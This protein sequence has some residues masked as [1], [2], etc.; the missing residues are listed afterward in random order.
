MMNLLS[1]TLLCITNV[2]AQT[3]FFIATDGS[4]ANG[5]TQEKP[6][7][8][9]K[10]AQQ[11]IQDLKE[12]GKYPD[13]G[14]TVLLRGGHYFVQE[15][16]NLKQADS[17]TERGGVLY[18]SYPGETVRLSGAQL[19]KGW[20]SVAGDIVKRLG[21][22]ARK[23][24]L[25]VNLKELGIQNFGELKP[26][27]MGRPGYS[28]A[29]ELLFDDRPMTLARYPNKGW[30]KIAS[31]P[32]GKDGGKFGYSG[33][34]PARW[35]EQDVWVHG[36]WTYDWADSYERAKRVDSANRLIETHPPHGKY[37]YRKGKRF[38][39][40]NV[41]E[42]LDS[43]GEW[44]L[45]RSSGMLYFWPP[46]LAK[47]E[48]HAQQSPIEIGQA[49]VSVT[50]MLLQLESVSN[51]E[52]RGLSFEGCR[53]TAVVIRGGENNRVSKCVFRNIGNKAVSIA[54][55][56]N[57]GVVGCDISE[58]GDGGISLSGGDRKTLTPAGH[59][60]ENNHIHHYSR[61][62]RTYR[63]GVMVSGVGNRVSHN[64][65]HH[66]PHNGIQL[67]GNDHQIEFNELHNLCE[68]TGDVG[69]FYMGRDWTARGTVIR[70]NFFHHIYGP[71]THGAM[72]VYLDDTASGITIYGNVFL[73]ASRAAFVG[74]GR[75]NTIENN[76]FV[77]CYPSVHIDARGLTW[78]AKRGYI[79]KGGGWHMYQKLENVKFNLPP[80]SEKYPKLAA[81]LDGDPRIP[82]GNTV[83]RNVSFGGRWLNLSSVKKE[84][85]KF[86]DNLVT[87]TNPGFI[88]L[89]RLNLQ[90][91][92]DSPAFKQ[93]FK[94]IPFEKIGLI[95]NDMRAT[96]P[97]EHPHDE[98]RTAK[99]KEPVPKRRKGPPPVYEIPL[100]D[101]AITIDGTVDSEEWTVTGKKPLLLEYT[102]RG[103]KTSPTSDV[104]VVRDK[105]AL[106]V[107]FKNRV[108]ARPLKKEPKWGKN[109]AVEIALR[110]NPNSPT[111]VL[112]GFV[113]GDFVSSDEAG[114]APNIAKK[115]A[116]NVGYSAS[117]KTAKEWQAEWRIP[118]ASIDVDPAKDK[119]LEF[120]LTVHQSEKS[121][122][123]MWVPTH[124]N[125]WLVERAGRVEWKR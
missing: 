114:A 12:K 82:A 54:G 9:I 122:W 64:L 121:V 61:W 25:Q 103:Q 99:K 83:A 74:G 97:V 73:K 43:P 75:D 41:L 51:V 42:E 37:G 34:R 96:W 39:Y 21:P 57:H 102:Y 59:Y 67:G 3:E 93:G 111:I 100:K 47:R 31:T 110:K 109:D 106:Y 26:R 108:A 8:S 22:A 14:V 85:V 30:E 107:A 40:L 29:L 1:I 32:A 78:A 90:L 89:G 92:E 88:D 58:T 87:E 11:A 86:E 24:V 91:K 116:S 80:Y 98:V 120:N 10:R 2:S 38:Y 46:L 63:P 71:Y 16:I 6:F 33:D 104:W 68:E 45:D 62:C 123:L 53:Q 60:A 81:I 23:N 65:I 28:A 18:S 84:W 20:K 27:G 94:R 101:A 7:G 115:A 52:F 79:K 113:N 119:R 36:Y 35:A 17:G 44:Y 112:R 117:Q 105:D 19:V 76:V 49:F 77:D 50:G 48:D 70:H 56:K 124:G 72:G 4:D 69:A 55:G 13:K 125:S 5:G 95:R 118:L 66:S 15:T